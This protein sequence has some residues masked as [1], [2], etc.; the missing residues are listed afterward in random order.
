MTR[1]VIRCGWADVPH[2]TDS[3]I[4][5]MTKGMMPH[6]KDARMQG[7]PSL[8]SGAIYPVAEEDII[9]DPQEFKLDD[10]WPRGFSLDVGW[11]K[12]AAVWGAYDRDADVV[13][14]Y[15]EYYRGHAEPAVHASAIKARGSWIPGI[16]D[17]AANC[18]S[19]ADGRKLYDLYSAEGLILSNANKAVDAG[20]LL[21]YQMLSTGRLKVSKNMVNWLSEFR[22]YRRDDKGRI[23]K[24]NDHLMDATRYLCMGIGN[25]RQMPISDYRYKQGDNGRA[26]M[27]YNAFENEM[28]DTDYSPY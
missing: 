15:D 22:I 8:G 13:Y 19:Q 1:A 9:F 3:M 12:N 26:Q 4:E 5:E 7:I 6:L 20:L 16:I 27:S 25:F 18:S 17:S 2:L 24:E 14:L 23:V 11:R 10:A 21:V 28:S